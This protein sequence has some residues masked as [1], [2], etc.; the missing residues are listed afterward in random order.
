MREGGGNLKRFEKIL[1]HVFY[2]G[3]LLTALLTLISAAALIYIFVAELQ[4]TLIAYFIYAMS[5]Y[6]LT[7]LAINIPQIA[8]KVKIIIY[9]NKLGNRYMMDVPFRV[10]TSLYLALFSNLLYSVFKLLTGVHY[11]SFWYGADALYYIILSVVRFL[12]LRHVRKDEHDSVEEYRKYRY[13]GFLLF[14]LNA[15]LIGVV[16]QVVNQDMGYQY[17]GLLIYVVATY[18]FFFLIIAIVN[19]IKYNRLNSPVLSAVKA[20]SLAKALVAMFALQ[21]SMFISFGGD[22]SETFMRIMKVLTGSGVCL[23]I[24]GMAVFMVIRANIN[25]RM[26]RINNSETILKQNSNT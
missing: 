5:T 18:T 13:C 15:A 14:A 25:L 1:Q 11:A 7:I 21:T 12:L 6:S 19:V 23:F 9:G 16:Y 17:P 10:K 8:V 26:L 24:F 3:V 22:E 2:P 20:I 4:V